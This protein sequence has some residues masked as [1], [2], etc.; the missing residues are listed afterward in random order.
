MN[1]TSREQAHHFR[2]AVVATN[3]RGAVVSLENE[4]WLV[5]AF[6]AITGRDIDFE[7]DEFN[8]RFRVQCS[9]RKF[10]Y[11]VITAPVMETL[12]A[13]R[14]DRLVWEAGWLMWATTGSWSAS[15]IEPTLRQ[16][17]SLVDLI[18]AY[19]LEPGNAPDGPK[20]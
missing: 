8:R 7:S 12:L 4:N 17:H 19:L 18:P 6:D 13:M 2:V 3:L 20:F 5:R 1:T 14:P 15:E 9:N 11:D 16:L 10:A